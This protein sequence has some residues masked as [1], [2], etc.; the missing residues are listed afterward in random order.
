MHMYRLAGKFTGQTSH[1]KLRPSQIK[2]SSRSWIKRWGIRR[3]LKGGE[4]CPS[5][6]VVRRKVYRFHPF[7]LPG[8]Y[9]RG[10]WFLGDCQ[11]IT[12][13]RRAQRSAWREL[14]EIKPVDPLPPALQSHAF[15]NFKVAPYNEEPYR[16]CSAYVERFGELK[17]GQGLILTGKS[18]TGK[19]HLA[20]AVANALKERYV[21]RFAHVPLLEKMRSGS[22]DLEALVNAQLLILD[23][24][25]S[26]RN[27]L[28][29]RRLLIIVEG[30]LVHGR[31]TIYTTNYEAAD[32]DKR[33][34][35]RLAS[36]ILGHNVAL[37]LHGPDYRLQ[38]YGY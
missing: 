32:L 38:R 3:H 7:P 31:P 13:A 35:M 10:Q 24:I 11:C 17:N 4:A 33:L 12:A 1:T 25:G 18:G 36:R 9:G 15:D 37:V 23:D 21:V 26:E 16:I 27:P 5:C 20:C 2:S 30:R 6:G 19:T 22:V 8:P 14:I 34:G 29:H 28:D